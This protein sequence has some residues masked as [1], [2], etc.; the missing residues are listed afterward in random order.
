VTT[1]SSSPGDCAHTSA[2]GKQRSAN[3]RGDRI[4]FDRITT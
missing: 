1:A 3:N 2:N 4:D